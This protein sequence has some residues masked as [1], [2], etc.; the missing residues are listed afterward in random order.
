MLGNDLLA[1]HTQHHC[2]NF[3]DTVDR[4]VECRIDR[5]RFAVTL[6][7]ARDAG[8]AAP[9]Q[10]RSRTWPTST[11]AQ[12]GSGGPRRCADATGSATGRCSSAWTG[13]TTRRASRSGCGPSDRLLDTRPELKGEFHFLQLGAPSRTHLP[14]YRDLNDEVQALA[15]RINWKHGTAGWQPVVFLNEHHGPRGR[16]PAVPDGRRVRGQFA[17][18]RDEPGG[19]GVR[20]GPRRTSGGCW[21]CREFT[22]AARELT[23]AV[24]VNPL[25]VDELADGAA[26]GPDDAGRRAGAADAADAGPGGRP[27][28]LPLGRDAPVRGRRGWPEASASDL[29]PAIRRKSHP[30]T[31]HP[32]GRPRPDPRPAGP[33]WPRRAEGCHRE[34]GTGKEMVARAPY[35]YSRRVDKPFLVVNCAAIPESLLESELFGHEKGAF[36][37]AE[38]KRIGKFEQCDGGTIFLERPRAEV[39]PEAGT[40]QRGR[41]ELASGVPAAR[42]PRRFARRGRPDCR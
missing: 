18:R 5:E 30:A 14:A 34:S 29:S 36:T 26:R 35:H 2:N 38:R 4:T 33:G 1:F 16:L 40:P 3:L 10:R 28:H 11:S 24:L 7:R 31:E 37:G 22:G 23:D 42:D 27:Q 32:R 39:R 12:T 17:A 20:G 9:D 13:S 15:D 41:A 6:R 21:C 19:Q 25:D 8:P